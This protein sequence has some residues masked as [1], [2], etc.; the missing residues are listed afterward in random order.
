MS[1]PG[2]L[3]LH[4]QGGAQGPQFPEDK[5]RLTWH[6]PDICLLPPPLWLGG[7]GVTRP[8]PT[9]EGQPGAAQQKP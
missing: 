7:A 5:L 3:P 8:R 6:G 2:L 9:P 4:L 1:P